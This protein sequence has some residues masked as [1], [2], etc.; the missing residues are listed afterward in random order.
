MKSTRACCALLTQRDK[1]NFPSIT[2][3]VIYDHVMMRVRFTLL[4][5]TVINSLGPI[6]CSA[7][8]STTCNDDVICCSLMSGSMYVW[9]V[10]TGMLVADVI[11]D[12]PGMSSSPASTVK[13]PTKHVCDISD[14]FDGSV[15]ATDKSMVE[16]KNA[17]IMT[18]PQQGLRKLS[19]A[20]NISLLGHDVM[21]ARDTRIYR[22]DCKNTLHSSDKSLR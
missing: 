1:F 7:L 19:T 9:D 17:G 10:S 2:I 18:S 20:Q 13:S 22:C 15:H 12:L 8:N 4:F 11:N 3:G 16:L 5:I 21:V 6:Y 14:V